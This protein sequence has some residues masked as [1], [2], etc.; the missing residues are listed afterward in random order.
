MSTRELVTVA[1]FKGWQRVN[2]AEQADV[3]AKARAEMVDDVLRGVTKE[4]Q[5]CSLQDACDRIWRYARHMG[6]TYSEKLVT[7]ETLEAIGWV[8][9][10]RKGSAE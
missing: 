5:K 7:A 3:D 4:M 8:R 1:D 10:G 6:L 9:R 2:A